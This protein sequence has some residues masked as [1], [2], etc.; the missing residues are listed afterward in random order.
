MPIRSIGNGRRLGGR[1]LET[2]GRYDRAQAPAKLSDLR[3]ITI[4]EAGEVERVIKERTGFAV[5]SVYGE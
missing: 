5:S 1:F 4:E 2:R 3:T